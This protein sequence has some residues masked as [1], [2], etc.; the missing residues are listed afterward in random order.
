VKMLQSSIHDLRETSAIEAD[1]VIAE[2][3]SV[4]ATQ[5][6]QTLLTVAQEALLNVRRHSG[7][8]TVI[9]SVQVTREQAVLVVQDNG[10]GI[11]LPTLQNYTSNGI[12]LG[13]KGMH[14]RIS[15]LG[16]Q[17]LLINGEEGGLIVK[18][19]VPL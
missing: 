17:F 13:L 3:A 9:V 8:T 14:Q 6:E 16:G 10:N 11:A 2:W 1:L 15:E 5:I 12:H 4:L 19:V 18:A 7:A